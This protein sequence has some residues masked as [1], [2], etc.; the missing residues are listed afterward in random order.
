M[1]LTLRQL[2]PCPFEQA[3]A[4]IKTPRLMQFIAHP[5]VKFLPADGTRVPDE[6]EATTYWFDLK[7][8]GLIPFG[9]QAVSISF[10]ESKEGFRLRDNGHSALITRWDHQIRISREGEQVMYEDNIDLN[11]GLLTPLVWVFARI[12][13]GHR[14]RRWRKLAASGFDYRDG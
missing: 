12:F 6:W 4:Q 11:A 3:V 2:L 1:K 5:L 7:L 10:P 13:F 9:K 14:H 8:F